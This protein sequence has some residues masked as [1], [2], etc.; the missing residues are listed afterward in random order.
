MMKLK[1]ISGS[2][3]F[4]TQVTLINDEKELPLRFVRGI[5][6]GMTV[7]DPHPRIFLDILPDCFEFVINT[8]GLVLEDCETGD[9]YHVSKV[10]ARDERDERSKEKEG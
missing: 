8:S 10:E 1:L 3:P 4:D 5:H 6:F 2:G 7:D 9:R